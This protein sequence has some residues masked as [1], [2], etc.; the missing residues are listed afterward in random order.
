L[1]AV[2]R[3]LADDAVF[4]SRVAR[5]PRGDID[6]SGLSSAQHVLSVVAVS[7]KRAL[8]EAFRQA[9]AR[10]LARARR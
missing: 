9:A 10:R 5:H 2:A 6:Q 1:P 8:G 3:H 7:P 4:Q